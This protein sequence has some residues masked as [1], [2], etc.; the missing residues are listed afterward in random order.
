VGFLKKEKTLASLKNIMPTYPCITFF[1][2]LQVFFNFFLIIFDKYL[3]SFMGIV[4]E[5]TTTRRH[6]MPTRGLYVLSMW[7]RLLVKIT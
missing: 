6:L 4:F 1:K 5:K 2:M 3:P 7:K